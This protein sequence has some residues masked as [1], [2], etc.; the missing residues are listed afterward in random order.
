MAAKYTQGGKVFLFKSPIRNILPDLL[1]MFGNMPGNILK[2][3][4]WGYFT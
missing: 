3:G 1:V 4:E 2:R